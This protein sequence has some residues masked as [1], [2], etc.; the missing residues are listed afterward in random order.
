MP[1]VDQLLWLQG[2][3]NLESQA[4]LQS[5]DLERK[6]AWY[7]PIYISITSKN[8]ALYR[9]SEIQILEHVLET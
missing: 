5:M 4:A 3:E 6:H 7:L 2:K 8:H 9:T 1:C